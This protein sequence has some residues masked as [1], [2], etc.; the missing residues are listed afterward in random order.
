MRLSVLAARARAIV[1]HPQREWPAIAAEDT[2]PAAL[3]AW[4]IAPLAAIGPVSH[5]IG[6]VVTSVQV[7]LLGTLPVSAGAGLRTMIA[8]YVLGL[9][10]VFLLALIANALAPAF[11]SRRSLPQA[12]KLVAYAYTPGWLAGI[13][14]I[15]PLLGILVLPASFYALYLV[16]LGLPAMMQCPPERAPAYAAVLALLGIVAAFL[17]SLAGHAFMPRP[18]I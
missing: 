14:G 4:Y 1:L 10:A 3:Y 7:P 11:G 2:A 8:S 5:F 15:V 9:A 12:L 16:Y 18:S 17:L 13:F 6:T